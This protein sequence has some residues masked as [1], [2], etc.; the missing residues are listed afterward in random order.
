MSRAHK[1]MSLES[2][3]Y[4]RFATMPCGLAAASA[5]ADDHAVSDMETRKSLKAYHDAAPQLVS[6]APRQELGLVK[7]HKP[8]YTQ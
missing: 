7:L 5:C 3:E 8:N 2:T 6:S 4:N 1:S